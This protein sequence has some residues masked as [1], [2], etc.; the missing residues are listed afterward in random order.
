MNPQVPVAGSTSQS[1]L[2]WRVAGICLALAAITF[3]VF[4]Q[5]LQHQFVNFDDGE[6]VA[7]NPVV[8]QGLTFKGLVWAFAQPHS[9]NWHPLTWLSHMLDCELYGLDPGG[10]HLTNVLLHTGAAIALFLVLLRMTGSLWP[11]AFVA[12]VFAIH[13]LRAESVAWVS[14]RKDVLSGLFFMLTLLA[15]QRYVSKVGDQ[16]SGEKQSEFGGLKS[17]IPLFCWYFSALALFAL[18]LMIKPMLVTLPLVLLLLDYWPVNRFELS[19]LTFRS[20][21]AWRLVLEKLP[22]VALSACSSVVTLLA[23]RG[24]MKT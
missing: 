10:H 17:E 23:Q 13:P 4:G 9:G 14:E 16:G 2:R 20:S 3:A 12:A 6:Y 7:K 11:S 24:A 19:T 22:F 21:N 1:V 18:G 5:T 8:A 15:Y